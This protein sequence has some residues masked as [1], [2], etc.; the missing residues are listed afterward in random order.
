MRTLASSQAT[1]A[2]ANAACEDLRRQ[3]A[4]GQPTRSSQDHHYHH[5]Q[6]ALPV[7]AN[8][9]LQRLQLSSLREES[10]QQPG[11]AD[12]VAG[13]SAV[14]AVP[15]VPSVAVSRAGGSEGGRHQE[16]VPYPMPHPFPSTSFSSSAPAYDMARLPPTNAAN[17]PWQAGVEEDY[18]HVGIVGS[19][20]T[21]K[22]GADGTAATSGAAAVHTSSGS[23]WSPTTSTA[24]TD[25]IGDNNDTSSSTGYDTATAASRASAMATP[26]PPARPG[27]SLH[28]L[29]SSGVGT[30]QPSTLIPQLPLSQQAALPPSLAQQQQQQQQARSDGSLPGLPASSSA[31]PTIPDLPAEKV[32]SRRSWP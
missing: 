15:A 19:T 7:S 3:L 13:R 27:S 1:S 23:P 5:H 6:E 8:L 24:P 31:S 21:G 2:A 20:T 25:N 26:P 14:A 11:P 28:L 18:D 9:P 30:Q 22:T 29:P 16:W 12:S 10:S 17:R 32:Q 4:M